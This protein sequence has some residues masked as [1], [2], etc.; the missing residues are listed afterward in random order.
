MSPAF[1]KG[2]ETVFPNAHIT[3]DKSCLRKCSL[4]SIMRR[5][6]QQHEPCSGKHAI[7]G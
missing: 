5:Q 4:L 3:F 1:I 6:E 2:I 7:Y